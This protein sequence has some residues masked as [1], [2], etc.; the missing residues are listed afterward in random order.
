MGWDAEDEGSL[1]FHE[2]AI[3][4]VVCAASTAF[5]VWMRSRE[6]DQVAYQPDEPT[7]AE[8]QKA[9]FSVLFLGDTNTSDSALGFDGLL[10]SSDLAIANLEEKVLTTEDISQLKQLNV[11]AISLANDTTAKAGSEDIGKRVELLEQSGLRWFGAGADAAKAREPLF[12][13]AEELGFRIAV[14]GATGLGPAK[15]HAQL[16]EDAPQLSWI[17]SEGFVDQIKALKAEDPELYVVAYLHWGGTYKWKSEAQTRI[18]HA[19][20][21]AGANL[22]IGHGAHMMQELET[23]NDS[24]IVYGLG[25]FILSSRSPQPKRSDAVPYSLVARLLVD[26]ADEGLN[27][28][29]AL[30]PILPGIS[31][32]GT[33]GKFLGPKQIGEAYWPLLWKGYTY[34]RKIKSHLITKTDTFGHYYE[35]RLP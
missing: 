8:P 20:V 5:A 28:R 23:Y 13:E 21:D 26:D 29:L 14:I 25:D 7:I 11:T 3:L 30:Y 9:D 17:D 27:K 34:D 33:N 32:A 15:K 16:P 12:A 35:I 22:I 31:K 1:K 10:A 24:W 4:L 2:T 6:P 18:S 19:L